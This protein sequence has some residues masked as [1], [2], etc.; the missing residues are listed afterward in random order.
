LG[1]ETKGTKRMLWFVNRTFKFDGILVYKLGRVEPPPREPC[2]DEEKDRR[3][4]PLNE[5]R[6]PR[7]KRGLTP[8][9]S[10]LCRFC[11]EYILLLC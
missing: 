3:G 2:D 8:R 11:D 9:P 1:A 10:R 6:P 5:G 7:A 4:E